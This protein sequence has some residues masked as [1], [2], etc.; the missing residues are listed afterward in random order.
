MKNNTY[1]QQTHPDKVRA[2]AGNLG[3]Q[4]GWA[5]YSSYEIL[6]Y[7]NF[8]D[9]YS[10]SDNEAMAELY[11]INEK[12][13]YLIY[14]VIDIGVNAKGWTVD[15]VSNY[16]EESGFGTDGAQDIF[17]TVVGDPA[18]YLSYSQGYFEMQELRDQAENAISDF[19]PVTFHECILSAG[20]C[21]YVLLQQRVDK[22]IEDNQ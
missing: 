15:D 12:L 4:E 3:Y 7:Y 9:S 18:C 14:G 5:V 22:Y 16:L 11:S 10:T 8:D 1:F 19:D 17:D 6:P 20:P 21:N 2:L 13:G